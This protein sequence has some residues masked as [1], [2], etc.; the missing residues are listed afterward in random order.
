MP[1]GLFIFAAPNTYSYLPIKHMHPFSF[2]LFFALNASYITK[3]LLLFFSLLCFSPL[4]PLIFLSFLPSHTFSLSSYILLGHKKLKHTKC[5]IHLFTLFS[6]FL[7]FFC[8]SKNTDC[9]ITLT[10]PLTKNSFSC[11]PTL[12]CIH[13]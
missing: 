1:L 4:L 12:K 8:L 9:T 11:K 7:S 13:S 2:F 6:V 10:T 3:L 5:Y